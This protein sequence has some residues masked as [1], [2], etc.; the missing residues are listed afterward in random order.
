MLRPIKPDILFPDV[1]IILVKRTGK[2]AKKR[3]QE[4]RNA[5]NQF[6][7]KSKRMVYTN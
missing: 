1:I 3:I 6:N 2:K 5:V 4:T 7:F